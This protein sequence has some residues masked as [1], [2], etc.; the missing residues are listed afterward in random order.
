MGAVGE[1]GVVVVNDDIRRH[2]GVDDD[3]FDS[4]LHAATDELERRRRRFRA[5]RPPLDVRGRTCVVVDDGIATGATVT[6]A[7]RVLRRADVGRIVLAVPVA[8]PDSL[9]AV[10]EEADDVVCPLQPPLFGAVGMFYDDFGQV[11]DDEVA[12]IL[13]THPRGAGTRPQPQPQH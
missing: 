2:A 1:D 6:A 13:R 8:A 3:D 10:A 7:L 11:T 9:A 4:V 12:E 5:G